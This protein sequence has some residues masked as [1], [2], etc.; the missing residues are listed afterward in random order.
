MATLNLYGFIERNLHRY[1]TAHGW[2][3]EGIGF[4]RHYT[5][6]KVV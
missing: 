2:W 1:T 4:Q 6:Q 5:Q 3:M